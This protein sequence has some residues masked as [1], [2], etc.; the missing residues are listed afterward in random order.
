MPDIGGI[1]VPLNVHGPL[2]VTSNTGMV[3]VS[4]KEL[5]SHELQNVLIVSNTS[6][7]L[8]HPRRFTEERGKAII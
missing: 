1:T 2:A 5:T 3:G 7:C 8:R 4:E 6:R